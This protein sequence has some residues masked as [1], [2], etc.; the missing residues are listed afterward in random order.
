MSRWLPL[1][2]LA[3][4]AGLIARDVWLLRAPKP[5]VESVPLFTPAS[6]GTQGQPIPQCEVPRDPPLDPRL[7][8]VPLK[9]LMA[10][11]PAPQAEVNAALDA[12]SHQQVE[13]RTLRNRRHAW[14]VE[15]MELTATLT[16]EIEP[17]QLDWILDNRDAAASMALR[18]E[19]WR[20][21]WLPA[22]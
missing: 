13:L 19:S 21:L 8:Q 17:E 18:P 12:V 16:R 6:L 3:L 22:P 14:N 2:C 15:A 11:A 4:L 9:A 20:D 10:L 7:A 5:A 1:T